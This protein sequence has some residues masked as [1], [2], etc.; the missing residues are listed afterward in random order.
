MPVMQPVQI[1]DWPLDPLKTVIDKELERSCVER[2]ERLLANKA[3]ANSST[4]E[5]KVRQQVQQRRKERKQLK[6]QN[7]REKID[8]MESRVR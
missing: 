6:V 3:T 2:S 5:R 1:L 8:E 7:R 4:E